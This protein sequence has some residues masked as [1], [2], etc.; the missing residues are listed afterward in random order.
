MSIKNTL[1]KKLILILVILIS[2]PSYGKNVNNLLF[3]LNNKIYTTIDLENRKKYLRLINSP[4]TDNEEILDDYIKV[5]FFDHFYRNNNENENE[6]FGIINQYYNDLL[7]NNGKVNSQNN[8]KNDKTYQQVKLEMQRKILIERELEKFRNIIFAYNVEEISNIYD[9]YISYVSIDSNIKK[10]LENI[11][12]KK[13]LG[14]ISVIKRLL[15]E[16]NFSYLFK[17]KKLN[18]TEKLD[19]SIKDA[20]DK[21]MKNFILETSDNFIIGKIDKIIKLH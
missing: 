21:N 2:Y 17:S 9:I 3:S 20:I 11:L 14:D 6:L 15:D 7:K 8:Y 1:I 4:L 18:N 5:I 19:I 16:N 12:N 13:E 10:K